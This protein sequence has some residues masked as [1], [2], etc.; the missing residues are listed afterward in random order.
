MKFFGG[1]SYWWNWH[2][3]LLYPRRYE[4]KYK[5]FILN[6]IEYLWRRCLWII[7]NFDINKYAATPQK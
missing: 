6:K 7:D 2:K 1:Y 5:D 4:L 3:D